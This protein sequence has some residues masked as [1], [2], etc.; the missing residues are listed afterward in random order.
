MD[1]G[2][3]SFNPLDSLKTTSTCSQLP[4]PS[5]RIFPF[6]SFCN[7]SLVFLS[8]S[9]DRLDSL[10]TRDFA[11]MLFK[12]TL[13]LLVAGVSTVR[14]H[15]Y[16]Q[17]VTIAGKTYQAFHPFEDP[18]AT[19][20]PQT[21][22]RKVADDGPIN[23]DAAELTCNKNGQQGNGV[24]ASVEA[25]QDVTWVMNRWPDDHKGPVQV[26]M[27]NCNGDCDAFDGSG[28]VWFK[29][30][31]QGLVDASKFFWASDKLIQA[32]NSWTQT[33]PSNI[34]AGNYLMRLE[35]V[36][37]HSAGA[38]QFYPSCTQLSVT[39]GG[40]GVPSSNEL[41]SIPG[42]YTQGDPAIFG[43]I[44]NQ[45]QSWPQV[46]PNVA[47]FV[48]GGSS[49]PA[50]APV[51]LPSTSAAPTLSD[52][53]PTSEASTPTDPV[54]TAVEPET[55]T[56]TKSRASTATAK[57]THKT[58]RRKVAIVKKNSHLAKREYMRAVGK[59]RWI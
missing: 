14:A 50:P 37:L 30:S 18:Y 39:G 43:N 27:A 3:S 36:A 48:S 45:P 42:V 19:P 35:L 17:N 6:V 47:A 49:N 10:S 40:N 20:V 12:S 34:K 56:S 31:S 1:R 8:H 32:G 11:N 41:V 21:V 59:K 24:T 52:P 44:W 38:P 5:T 4:F 25:G 9:L 23:F 28:P 29:V 22:V 55:T 51:P 7:L 16:P 57:P 13:A 54:P 33:I 26:Y 58:C 53:V 2:Q 15:G 46:G